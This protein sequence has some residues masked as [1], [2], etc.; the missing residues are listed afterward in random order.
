MAALFGNTSSLSEHHPTTPSPPPH[1]PSPPPHTPS[2]PLHN[3]FHLG[4]LAVSSCENPFPVL[5]SVSHFLHVQYV[6]LPVSFVI[7][8]LIAIPVV[9]SC[10]LSPYDKVY[11]GRVHVDS[12]L[13]NYYGLLFLLLFK[14]FTCNRRINEKTMERTSERI[15]RRKAEGYPLRNVNEH[16]DKSGDRKTDCR[17]SANSKELDLNVKQLLPAH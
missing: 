13:E 16:L 14:A 15:Q 1:T 6:W 5:S 12:M 4:N 2:P 7:C 9:I 3:P 11:M 17:F 10:R 8:L